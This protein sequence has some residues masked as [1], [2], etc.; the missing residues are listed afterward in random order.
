MKAT[1]SIALLFLFLG[2]S[3]GYA[4]GDF[5]FKNDGL[6]VTQTVSYTL[7]KN[8]VEGTLESGGYDPDTSAETFEFKGTKS[9]NS[10]TVKFYNKPP[11]ELPPGTKHIVWTLAATG[12]KVPM[13]GKNYR[14]GLYGT[15]IATFTKCKGDI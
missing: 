11:F 3:S 14:S 4:Q 7:T 15:Y 12:L 10:L 1:V 8:K 13:Y 2:A 9:G 6:K 5:C